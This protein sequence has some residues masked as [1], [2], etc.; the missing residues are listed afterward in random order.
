[1]QTVKA[2]ADA[3]GVTSDVVRHYT[4]CKLVTPVTNSENKYK[5][6]DEFDFLQL[7][8]ARILRSLGLPLSEV[9]K[10]NNSSIAHQKE[11]LAE[12]SR[13]VRV[14]IEKL[15]ELE[16]RLHEVQ[17]Y[18]GKTNRCVP[19]VEEVD[20]DSIHSIYTFGSAVPSK[21]IKQI[22]KLWAEHFPF[23]HISIKIPKEELQNPAFAGPYS[24]SLGLGVINK[25]AEQFRLEI[26][27][28]IETIPRGRF[29][30]VKDIFNLTRKDLLPLFEKAEE[31]EVRFSHQSSGRLLAIEE[32][33]KETEFFILIRVRIEKN[34]D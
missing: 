11:I 22:A 13:Q 12:K 20:R 18:L 19:T 6:Y 5:Y 2:I 32:N 24:V 27:P 7:A 26:A 29:L 30:K 25:Y 14:Q 1:M 33:G 34:T 3:L 16:L 10:Y 8:N 28:P 23:T 21:D 31:L 17:G 15:Q 9:L 4:E